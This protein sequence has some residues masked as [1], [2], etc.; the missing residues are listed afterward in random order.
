MALFDTMMRSF[1]RCDFEGGTA[2]SKKTERHLGA[3]EVR[4][5]NLSI[6]PPREPMKI[7]IVDREYY[8]VP[9]SQTTHDEDCL[10]V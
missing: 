5:P 4:R 9:K 8:F 10:I 1:R 7:S 6:G 3:S 2:L